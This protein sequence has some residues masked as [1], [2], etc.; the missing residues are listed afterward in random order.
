M[1]LFYAKY[2]TPW[3]QR[4]VYL[5]YS[6]VLRRGI[7]LLYGLNT[8]WQ[9]RRMDDYISW[10]LLRNGDM[11]LHHAVIQ[12]CPNVRVSAVARLGV[13]QCFCNKQRHE[14]SCHSSLLL[15]CNNCTLCR[16]SLRRFCMHIMYF[17]HASRP[18][19]SADS[20]PVSPFLSI[21]QEFPFSCHALLYI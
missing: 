6:C 4:C 11:G 8:D 17:A 9:T 12:T 18:C 1:C 19:C 13:S 21:F 10:T 2:R 14:F 15:E 20:S 16:L 7:C 3:K 5:A